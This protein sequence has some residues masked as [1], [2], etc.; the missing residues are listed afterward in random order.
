MQL[1]EAHRELEE[2]K[3]RESKLEARLDL[4]VAVLRVEVRL[5]R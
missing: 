5:L 1:D 3:R 4:E 2:G